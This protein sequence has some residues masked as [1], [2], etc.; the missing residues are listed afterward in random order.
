SSGG[1]VLLEEHA[2]AVVPHAAYLLAQL[3]TRPRPA[4]EADLLVV[5]G[6]VRYD[7][8]PRAPEGG[9]AADLLAL[10]ADR[11]GKSYVI[12]PYLPGSEQ[13][14]AQVLARAGGRKTLSRR[15]SEASVAQLT[16]DLPR[17]RWAHLATHGFF[18]DRGT[19][20]VL[21][22]APEDYERARWGG[23]VGV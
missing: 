22:L 10:N 13:E 5:Y 3:Q 7:R 18:D 11:G 14:L 15:G 19:R 17:A 12:W 2:V 9:P 16:Q 4:A 8:P 23:R 21:Q 1:R 20:S 6:A